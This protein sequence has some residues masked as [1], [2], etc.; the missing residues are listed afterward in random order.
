ML[1]EQQITLKDI[2]YNTTFTMSL[3]EILEEINRDRSDDWVEYDT[4]DW[5]E[6]LYEFTSWE[7][8]ED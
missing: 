7:I 2:E 1:I 5:R 4:D 3:A 8:V 6:G